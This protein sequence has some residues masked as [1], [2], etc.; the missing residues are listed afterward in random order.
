MDAQIR[1][2]VD[3]LR[4]LKAAQLR[5]KYLE[6]FGETAKSLNKEQTLRRLAW[7][8]QA[9]AEG[10]LSER[11]RQR[12]ANSRRVP[13]C[14]SCRR[15][16]TRCPARPPPPQTSGTPGAIRGCRYPAQF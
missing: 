12:A 2:E 8:L 6:W 1:A 4:S 11:A 15:E 13:S 5:R 16:A 10:G 7:R 14:G 3:A 9:R